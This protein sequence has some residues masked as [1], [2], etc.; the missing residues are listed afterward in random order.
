M[1]QSALL[2]L[3]ALTLA[4]CGYVGDPKPPTLEIPLPIQDLRAVQRGAHVILDFTPN[5][6]TTDDLILKEFTAVELRAGASPAGGFEVNRW[7]AAAK[8]FPIVDTSIA[9]HEVTIPTD[10]LTSQEIIFAVR[11]TGPKN[12][13]SAWSNLVTLKIVPTLSVPTGLA[14][15]GTPTGVYLQWNDE[16]TQPESAWRIWRLAEGDKDPTVLGSATGPSW[17][18]PNAEFGKSYTYTLQQ[19]LRVGDQQEAESDLTAAVIIKYEDKFPPEVPKGLTGLAGVASIDL[20]WD[21]NQETDLRTYTLYRAEG[22]A[23]LQKLADLG[24]TPNYSDA[25]IEKGKRYRYAVTATDQ[26]GNTSAQSA[27][28]EIAAP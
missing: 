16:H 10:G 27:P 28:I 4:G 12:R 1:R 11:T 26:L 9:P 15:T 20:T 14:A 22:D 2:P 7:A 24:T 5:P 8:K 25:K 3:F 18:D 17:L 19:T 23:P 6:K 13:S 21:R